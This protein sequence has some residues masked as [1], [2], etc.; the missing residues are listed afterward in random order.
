MCITWKYNAL[1]KSWLWLQNWL[2]QTCNVFVFTFMKHL[3]K[4]RNV[5]HIECLVE[6]TINHLV[7][8]WTIKFNVKQVKNYLEVCITWKVAG[9]YWPWRFN[10]LKA[11]ATSRRQFTFYHFL[12]TS[13]GWKPD[14]TLEPPSEFEHKNPELGI[15]RL[16]H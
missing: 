13:E 7:L 2:R 14:L 9:V 12:S 3:L 8:I 15:Q 11:I 16:N 10:Y 5:L 4:R 6:K 1:N